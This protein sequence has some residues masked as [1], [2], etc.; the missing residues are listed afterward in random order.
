[1]DECIFCKIARKEIPAEIIR[2]GNDWICFKDVHPKAPVHWL[3]IPKAHYKNFQ[4]VDNG[5]LYG[6]L[7]MG[8][9]EI[10]SE[11]SLENGGFRIVINTGK[12]GG[13]TVS[14]LHFHILAKRSMGWP[15]G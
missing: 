6:N 2:E 4:S 3:V 15:P 1:M 11:H 12:D 9:R 7:M 10:V 14:H 5:Q 13:Q 8:I